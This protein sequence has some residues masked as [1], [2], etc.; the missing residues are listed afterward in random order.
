MEHTRYKVFKLS[1][2]TARRRT[3][4]TGLTEAEAQRYVSNDIKENGHSK[5]TMLCYTK[6]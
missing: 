4:E 2:K 6:Q 5:L 3:I 1:K